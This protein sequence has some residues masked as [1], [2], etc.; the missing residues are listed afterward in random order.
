M[1]K[2]SVTATDHL[3]KYE[4]HFPGQ[5]VM[6]TLQERPPHQLM[7]NFLK[8]QKLPGFL[9]H[10]GGL[11]GDGVRV[12]YTTYSGIEEQLASDARAP[13]VLCYFSH[14]LQGPLFWHVF[15]ILLE[16]TRSS[17]LGLGDLLSCVLQ[18]PCWE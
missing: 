13:G 11:R 16:P 5:V 8:K 9:M 12:L 1:S 7:R 14:P 10:L 18:H 17:H 3:I 15:L 4:S 2:H 6:K